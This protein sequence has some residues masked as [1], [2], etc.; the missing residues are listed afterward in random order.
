MEHLEGETLAARLERLKGPLPLDQVLRYGGEIA[1]AL[2][3]AH[4]AG[5]V[6]RDLKPANIMLTKAGAKLLDFGLAKLKGPATPISSG[7]SSGTRDRRSGHGD[8]DD[9]RH[10][11]LHGAGAGGRAR[12]GRAQRHLGAGRGGLR[13]GDRHAAV[14]GRR[15][16]P[17]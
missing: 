10:G 14:R 2:D 5:I 11:A 12:G 15:R 13:D 4:R 16:R 1:D 8:G 17:V 7:G 3:K 6:H 9:S